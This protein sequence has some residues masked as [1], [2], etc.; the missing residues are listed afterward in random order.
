MS[1]VT[2]DLATLLPA[3]RARVEVL[4]VEMR[5]RA[6]T[7]AG[8]GEQGGLAMIDTGAAW[9]RRPDGGNRCYRQRKPIHA[10]RLDLVQLRH[11]QRR[12]K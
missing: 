6:S 8:L 9:S 4:L 5:A 1:G 2:R 11:S 7:S 10:H 12:L 3:F